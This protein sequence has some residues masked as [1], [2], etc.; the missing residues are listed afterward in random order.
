MLICAARSWPRPKRSFESIGDT[1]LGQVVRRHLD[2]H[3]VAGK[4]PDTV[5]AH[6]AG[7]VS[8]DLVLVL[9]L[10]AESGVREQLRHDTRK[11]QQ[12]FLCHP[13][14]SDFRAKG[15]RTASPREGAE[16]SGIKPR[17]QP[18]RGSIAARARGDE[19]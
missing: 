4:H 3:L 12:L 5:L 17:R 10:D 16:T 8:D 18:V 2:Q 11:F 15:T 13:L 9:E 19:A 7:G 14:P 1:T 6:A